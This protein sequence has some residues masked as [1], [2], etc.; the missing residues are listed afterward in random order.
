[1]IEALKPS[2]RFQIITPEGTFEMTKADFY[3]VFPNV[4]RTR[5][6]KEAGVYHYPKVPEAALEFLLRK[7]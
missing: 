5:S 1:M 3:R 7:Q 2:D 6:Y 4:V